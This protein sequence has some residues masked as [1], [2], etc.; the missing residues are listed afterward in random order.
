M[1]YVEMN[2]GIPWSLV[3]GGFKKTPRFNTLSQKTAAGRGSSSVSLMP[4][5]GW[6]FEVDLN[7]VPGGES[8]RFSVLQ[9]FLGCYIATCGGGAYFL[10]TDPNDNA[11][12]D[13]EQSV[14]L[15]VTPG[16]DSPMGRTGDG[17][18]TAFQLAR[19][20][21]QGVDVLQN[22]S[23]VEVFVNGVLTDAAIS[24]TGVA[25]FA[26]APADNAALTWNGA[27]R[28]LCQF[29]DDRLSGL[30]R[31]SKNSGGFLW[32]CSSITF[33]SRFI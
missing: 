9:W 7:L 26:T 29:T 16:A 8:Q 12:D 10:F 20:I 33:E 6:D 24:D 18:S 30:A 31:E 2:T 14:L 13:Q 17:T 5:P 1:A 21:D 28:Y 27:F 23:N 11:V 22:V 19:L 25:T 32:S 4:Y 15:N 3:K